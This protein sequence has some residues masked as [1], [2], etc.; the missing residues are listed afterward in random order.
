VALTLPVGE[1]GQDSEIGRLVE[2]VHSARSLQA[3]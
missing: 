2:E 1:F 3:T